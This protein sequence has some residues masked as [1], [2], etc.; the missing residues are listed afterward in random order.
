MELYI[1]IPFCAKK[2]QYCSFVSF[3][4]AEGEKE[5][6][7]RA[8]LQ[9]ASIRRSEFAEPV[10]T[11]FIGG[12]TPSLLSA[13]QLV[14]LVQD[15]RKQISILPD[16]EFTIEA[17]PGTITEPFVQAARKI[18]INRFSLGMQAYQEKLLSLLGRIHTFQQVVQS[19][20]LLKKYQIS[21][22]NLDLMFGI[23]GQTEKDWKQTVE[24]AI[25]L[26]PTHIS[27]YGLIPEEGT[28]LYDSLQSG[29]YALPEPEVERKMYG[30]AIYM[31]S[32][33]GYF[34]YEISNFARAGCECKHNIGYW[35]QVP[36]VGLGISAASMVNVRKDKQGFQYVR[37]TNPCTLEQYHQMIRD[38]DYSQM[39]TEAISPGDARFETMMLALRMNRGISE[40]R[41][42]SL[43]GVTIESC[44]G[45]QLKKMQDF[46][47]MQ[48]KSASWMLTAKGMD[49]QNSILVELMEDVPTA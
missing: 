37:K 16:A 9:E 46:G 7:I 3:S 13:E 44:Y 33:S 17:N 6:Y 12:G 11:V 36:Y 38:R 45:K 49:I 32:Q 2:C 20:E 34:Q 29:K 41:F 18:G 23:P 5:E 1:H 31:L 24:A 19:V 28:P 48:H 43:H 14:W 4:A 15:L 40:E 47:L 27:A 21:N 30:E 39:E 25:S 8:V 10:T 35:T 42:Y 22:Y 26:H